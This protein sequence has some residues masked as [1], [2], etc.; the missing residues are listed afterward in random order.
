MTE[1]RHTPGDWQQDGGD[2]DI[3][4]QAMLLVEDVGTEREWSAVGLTD[5]EEPGLAC[6]VALCHP[7]NATRIVHCVNHFDELAEALREMVKCH[8]HSSSGCEC[9]EVRKARAALKRAGIE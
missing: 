5:G 2:I 4:T 1:Q 9:A 3:E 8:D 7:D 6:V